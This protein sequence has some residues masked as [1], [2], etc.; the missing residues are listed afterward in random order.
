MKYDR[1]KDKTEC[2]YFITFYKLMKM[3]CLNFKNVQMKE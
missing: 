1:K 3:K 2:H